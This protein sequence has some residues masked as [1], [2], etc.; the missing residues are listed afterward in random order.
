MQFFWT[1]VGSS[2]RDECGA[3]IVCT[4]E[5]RHDS[6]KSGQHFEV[7]AAAAAQ[8]HGGVQLWIHKKLGIPAN[9]IRVTSS[10][11]RHILAAIRYTSLRLDILVGHAP[12][13]DEQGKQ[14][15]WWREITAMVQGRPQP[16][17]D[18]VALLDANGRVG[19]ISSLAVG[20]VEPQEDA[21]GELLHDF[22]GKCDLVAANTFDGTGRRTWVQTKGQEARIDYVVCPQRGLPML[23]R[24]E[25]AD[26]S[27][28]IADK[29]DHRPLFAKFVLRE[30]CE[31]ADEGKADSSRIKFDRAR[32]GQ[33]ECRVHFC[34]L[35]P[36]VPAM[37]ADVSV[38]NHELLLT[39]FWKQC[40]TQACLRSQCVAQNKWYSEHTWTQ[41][42]LAKQERERFL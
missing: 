26:F 15:M 32:L 18:L 38:G 14:D 22:L 36:R 33:A 4:Q 7:F 34:Q 37:P 42:V 2:S 31:M 1:R 41:I 17:A 3:D 21:G 16:R 10:S 5:A 9:R 27:L 23:H 13:Q 20:A 29:E 28:A 12:V 30:E 35:L 11:S 40:L 39:T 25:T 8:G 6:Q 19:S 24:A